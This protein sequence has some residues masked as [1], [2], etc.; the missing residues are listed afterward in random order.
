MGNIAHPAGYDRE[1]VASLAGT[2]VC[3]DVNAREQQDIFPEDA[4]LAEGAGW[5]G[6]RLLSNI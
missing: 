4:L 5:F 6:G 3:S 2:H 1:D